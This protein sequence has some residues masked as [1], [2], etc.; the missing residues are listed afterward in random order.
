M[1]KICNL[2]VNERI[3]NQDN[4][5][6]QNG[7][8]SQWFPGLQSSILSFRNVVSIDGRKFTD[9]QNVSVH[10]SSRYLAKGGLLQ[11]SSQCDMDLSTLFK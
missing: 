2:S 3:A 10:I 7:A 6:E 9:V 8:E 1:L 11:R 5:R 4:D